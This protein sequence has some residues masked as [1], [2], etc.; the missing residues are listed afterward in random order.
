M[1]ETRTLTASMDN[2]D[3]W[4]LGEIAKAAGS[5]DRTDVGDPIDRGLV[6]LKLLNEKGYTV[7]V[8]LNPRS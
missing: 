3:A 4:R 8:Q 7:T 5:P 6:L 2:L 1:P